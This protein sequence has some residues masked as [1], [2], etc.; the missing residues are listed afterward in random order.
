[1]KYLTNA[2][3]EEMIQLQEVLNIKYN[4]P[5][6]RKN[7]R[8]GMAKFA[9]IDEVSEMAREI[10]ASWAW[11]KKNPGPMEWE[12]A[13]EEFIDVL[14]FALLIALYRYDEKQLTDYV[15][16]VDSDMGGPV[17][18]PHGYFIKAITRFLKAADDDNR[19]DLVK[20]LKNI[21][22][23]GAVLLAMEQD[24]VYAIYQE[25]NAKNHVRV[26]SG[27]TVRIS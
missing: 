21:V 17:G 11:W 16:A 7:I 24:D 18:D 25:K 19:T 1:M 2:Q 26:E 23:T 8:L 20:G 12:K 27:Q 4:G 9:L 5:D 10:R 14:H 3:L 6:W 13:R 22:E 15:C